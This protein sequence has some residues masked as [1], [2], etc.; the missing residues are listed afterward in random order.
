MTENDKAATFIGWKPGQRCER[1]YT[2][3]SGSWC[4]D[5]KTKDAHDLPAPDMSDPRNYMKALEACDDWQLAKENQMIWVERGDCRKYGI[6]PRKA[7]AAL[8]DAEHPVPK[9]TTNDR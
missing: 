3:Q 4:Y 2:L 6:T 5:H 9:E 7:L 1:W 8:Y